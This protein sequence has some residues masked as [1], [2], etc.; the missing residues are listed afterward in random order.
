MFQLA[1]IARPFIMIKA[2]HIPLLHARHK[3]QSHPVALDA[4][5]MGD[6]MRDIALAPDKGRNLDR[7]NGKAEPQILAE[8]PV[9]HLVRQIGMSGC[10][11]PHIHRK[12]LRAAHPPQHA[13]VQHP[14]QA[15]LRGRGHLSYFVQKQG[16]AF[17]HFKI[18]GARG[19]RSG[20]R[21][22]LVTKQFTVQ[23]A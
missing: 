12:E 16:A 11:D 4:D 21:P 9:R 14:Q 8:A 18:A 2:V 17:R 20:K 7:Q 23:Q 15:Y 19:L 5:E 10:N 3:G 22:L 1:H 6:Q 13:A